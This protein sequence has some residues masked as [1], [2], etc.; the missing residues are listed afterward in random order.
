M[1]VS[2]CVSQSI[3]EASVLCYLNR[4]R[5]PRWYKGDRIID[6]DLF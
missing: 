3:L 5:G 4:A 2:H 1:I 6:R